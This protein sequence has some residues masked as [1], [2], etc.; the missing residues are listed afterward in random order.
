MFSHPDVNTFFTSLRGQP[1]ADIPN[2]IRDYMNA[3]PQV[4]TDLTGIR[5]PLIDLR[6]RCEV[7]PE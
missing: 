4:K 3:N 1:N 2:T 5:Q 7:T 6:S